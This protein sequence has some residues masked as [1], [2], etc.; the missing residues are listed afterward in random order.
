MNEQVRDSVY[1]P[2]EKVLPRPSRTF[3]FG[4]TFPSHSPDSQTTFRSFKNLH[5]DLRDCYE[6]CS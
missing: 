4:I 2:D 1:F 5:F 3:M 6:E